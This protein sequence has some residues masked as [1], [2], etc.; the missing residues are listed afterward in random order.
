[1]CDHPG[2]FAEIPKSGKK[3]IHCAVSASDTMFCRY[4]VLTSKHHEGFTNW[5]SATAFNWNSRD[6][7][8]NRDLVGDLRTAVRKTSMRFGVYHSMMDWFHQYYLT[9]RQNNWETQYFVKV[10]ITRRVLHFYMECSAPYPI[11]SNWECRSGR[12]LR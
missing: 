5:P 3:E 6:V 1:M 10:S 8:P 7:G 11:S 9:D 4:V 2:Y 12:V